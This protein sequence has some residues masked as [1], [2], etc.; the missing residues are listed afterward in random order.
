MVTETSSRTG[1]LMLVDTVLGG[2]KKI[3]SLRRRFNRQ[4]VDLSLQGVCLRIS[5]AWEKAKRIQYSILEEI[6]VRSCGRWRLRLDNRLGYTM[7]AIK[8]AA[9]LLERGR[10]S[11]QTAIIR[12]WVP[13]IF[14]EWYTV[15]VWETFLGLDSAI[16]YFYTKNFAFC[17]SL[18][19]WIL[20]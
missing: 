5:W 16:C 11:M 19:R 3:F 8:G 17:T 14:L 18:I 7:L 1:R 10:C 13:N 20:W 4:H 12:A 9:P 6:Q 2:L 15:V